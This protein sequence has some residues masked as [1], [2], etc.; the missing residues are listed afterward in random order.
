MLLSHFSYS[1]LMTTRHKSTPQHSCQWLR[2]CSVWSQGT[3][4]L[5]CCSPDSQIQGLSSTAALRCLILSSSSE[6]SKWGRRQTEPK[7]KSEKKFKY[8]FFPIS[9]LNYLLILRENWMGSKQNWICLLLPRGMVLKR[10]VILSCRRP[11]FCYSFPLSQAYVPHC[12]E[13][14]MSFCYCAKYIFSG[15]CSCK[16]VTPFS[17]YT[18]SPAVFNFAM[19]QQGSELHSSVSLKFLKLSKQWYGCHYREHK[20]C[21]GC[22]RGPERSSLKSS[23]GGVFSL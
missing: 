17:S 1:I 21:L 8:L 6:M 18:P 11:L 14:P 10:S 20:P 9:E 22:D 13:I 23:L 15:A 19:V 12:I 16:P 4:H 2:L 7:A 5:Q 3:L